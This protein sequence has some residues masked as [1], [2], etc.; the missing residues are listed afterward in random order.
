MTLSDGRALTITLNALNW[1]EVREYVQGVP[2]FDPAHPD[3]TAAAELRHAELKG[4]CCGLSADEVLALG[5]EDFSR[6]SKKISDLIVNPV[7][8]DP[9]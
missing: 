9:S 6:I 2:A 8:A 5:F 1:R 7:S 4:R 3:E